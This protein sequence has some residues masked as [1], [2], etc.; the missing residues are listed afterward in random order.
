M[1]GPGWRGFEGSPV[2]VRTPT[3]ASLPPATHRPRTPLPHRSR[4]EGCRRRVCTWPGQLCVHGGG[5]S[6]KPDVGPSRVGTPAR[7]K[8]CPLSFPPPLRWPMR[9]PL[10][11]ADPGPAGGMGHPSSR[12]MGLSDASRCPQQPNSIQ[13]TPGRAVRLHAAGHPSFACV[14]CACARRPQAAVRRGRVEKRV[15]QERE[16][17]ATR[18]RV[19]HGTQRANSA[20]TPPALAQSRSPYRFIAHRTVSRANGVESDTSIPTHVTSDTP[21]AAPLRSSPQTGCTTRIYR[22]G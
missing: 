19:K 9:V 6:T 20:A 21:V 14:R 16:R 22:R 15:D 1:S 5:G 2:N 7:L 3:Q 11:R 12:T 8:P 18:L 17:R 10:G 4:L 13:F